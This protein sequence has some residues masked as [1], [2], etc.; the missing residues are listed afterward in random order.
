MSTAPFGPAYTFAFGTF[1]VEDVMDFSLRFYLWHTVFF[2]QGWLNLIESS[3]SSEGKRWQPPDG[4]PLKVDQGHVLQV[5]PAYDLYITQLST[6]SRALELRVLQDVFES[7]HAWRP[8]S[9]PALCG[10]G[11]ALV[12]P[13]VTRGGKALCLQGSTGIHGPFAH[14]AIHVDVVCILTRHRRDHA[15][16]KEDLCS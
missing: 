9:G 7:T 6:S 13:I 15:H 11:Y 16:T 14:E 1:P 4:L 5:D 3:G 8:F 12:Q 10:G 2:H